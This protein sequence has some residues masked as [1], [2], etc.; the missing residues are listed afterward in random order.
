MSRYNL[1]PHQTRK[2][3]GH[4]NA[5]TELA[6][7]LLFVKMFS[8]RGSSRLLATSNTY[9]NS[10]SFKNKKELSLMIESHIEEGPWFNCMAQQHPR[11]GLLPWAPAAPL[12]SS[13][14]ISSPSS[15]PSWQR[16]PPGSS[17]MQECT[18]EGESLG[19]IV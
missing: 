2:L 6:T 3:R 9:P 7:C 16:G 11:A 12:S 14:S 17:Q 13:P 4:R 10:A 1:K 8:G 5:S 15:S 18:L 19:H